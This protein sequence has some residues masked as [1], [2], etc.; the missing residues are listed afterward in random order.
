MK[1]FYLLILFFLLNNIIYSQD[2]G[3]IPKEF[4]EMKSLAED[5]EEDAAVIFDKGT[6]KITKEFDLEITRFKRVKVFTEEGKKQANIKIVIYKKDV[7]SGI[8]AIAVSPDGKEYELDSDNIFEEEALNSKTISFPVP[9]VE[10][11]TVFDVKYKV[12]SE[13]IS[14]LEPWSF[15]DDIYTMYSELIVFLPSGFTYNKLSVNLENF[16]LQE[17]YEAITDRDDTRKK[18][19]KFTWSCQNLPGIKD[20]P[21]TDNID[22]NYAQLYFVL[23]AYADQYINLKFSENWEAVSKDI[24]KRYDD[25]IDNDDAE[26]IVKEIIGTETDELKKAK[27]IY[28]WVRTTIKTTDH[29]ALIGDEF[30]SP[31][32]VLEQ[33]AGGPSEKSMLLINMLYQAGLKAQPVW[34]STRSNGAI[35]KDFCDRTQFNRLICLLTIGTQRYFLFPGA[36]SIQ[37]GN[38]PFQADVREGL[39]LAE[40]KGSLV[41]IK[42]LNLKGSINTKTTGKINSDRSLKA[43]TQIS[44]DSF[45]A[46]DERESI[47]SKGTETYIKDW[48]K[49]KFAN[50]VL[51]SFY[52]TNLDSIYKPLIVNFNFTI[53]D[54]LEEAEPLAYFN[55]PFF[56]GFKEN[57]FTKQKRVN[58]VDFR[59]AEINTESV[60]IEF[61][62]TYML[63]ELPA[64]RKKMIINGSLNQVY[65]T[66]KNTIECG[67]T[68]DINSRR[69]IV[70]S[71]QDIK[72]FFDELV[73]STN[74]QIVITKKVKTGN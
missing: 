50:A 39:L 48:L 34:I 35:V 15:Q 53:P 64:K 25:L 19:G 14:N 3:E 61:P 10:A 4:L 2:F 51:D 56:S 17:N 58:P 11:G 45:S 72:S 60:K 47:T 62:D 29:R 32:K 69:Y 22:D 65:F 52:L 24:Y 33:K 43:S 8:E 49:E 13:Y 18:I 40:E 6:L 67:R 37:F 38:L 63:T 16:N 66:N 42:P 57:P 70:K 1:S 36:V 44:Y 74:E 26:E 20:E 27:L 54:Y 9:G 12:F 7:I 46:V 71:Y 21:F 30:A 23:V 31:E 28:D 5:P 55:L 73:S 68:T 59:Y 41:S